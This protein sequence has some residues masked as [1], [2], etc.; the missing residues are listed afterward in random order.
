VK[1]VP[2]AEIH[3]MAVTAKQQSVSSGTTQQADDEERP[4]EDFEATILR[5]D[6]AT[7]ERLLRQIRE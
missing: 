1:T 4:E 5:L 7:I 6:A 2:A 3:A